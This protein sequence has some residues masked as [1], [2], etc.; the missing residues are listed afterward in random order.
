MVAA[1]LALAG[2]A[3]VD[4]TNNGTTEPVQS[5]ASFEAAISEVSSAPRY[6]MFILVEDNGDSHTR[7]VTANFLMSAMLDQ[8]GLS[9]DPPGFDAALRIARESAPAHRLRFS[10]PAIKKM[11]ITMG[12]A[13]LASARKLAAGFSDAQLSAAFGGDLKKKPAPA[14]EPLLQHGQGKQA[15]Q[16]A[17]ACALIER[18]FS[19]LR[20]DLSG[21]LHLAR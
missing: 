18:G 2:C 1:A 4:P 12:D 7:C 11:A 5:Q 9:F 19:P 17:M 13:D 6:V 15:A 20:T 10:P 8:H 14:Y 16:A 3:V 21:Q